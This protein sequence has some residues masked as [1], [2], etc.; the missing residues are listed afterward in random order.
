MQAIETLFPQLEPAYR[1][2]VYFGLGDNGQVKIGITSRDNGRRGG[3]MHFTELCSVPGNRLVEQ[4]YHTTYAAERIGRTE[5]FHLSDQLLIDLIIMCVQQG[6][7]RST[8]ILK[9]ITLARL[10]QVAA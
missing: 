1:S 4:R 2:R 7:H 6:R 10:R 5:W 9:G 3:E 8:E